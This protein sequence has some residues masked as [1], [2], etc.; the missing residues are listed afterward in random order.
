MLR[1]RVHL[2]GADLN[3][4]GDTLV[5]DH[6]GMERLIP[7]GP[8]HRKKVLETARDRRPCLVDDAD[9][10]VAVPD[11]RRDHAKR[12]QVIDLLQRGP[13][14][15]DFLMDAIGPLDTKFNPYVGDLC[16][17]E[18][19]LKSTLEL[20][21]RAAGRAAPPLDPGAGR[22][23]RLGVEVLERQILEL[24][25]DLPHS[26]SVGDGRVDVQGLLPDGQSSPLRH[27]AE[28]THVVQPV[29]QL[30][31]NDANVV[32]HGEQH[33]AEV[34][35]LSFLA[36]G[37]GDGADLGDTF[38]DMSHFGPKQFS[39][40]LDRGECVLNDVME[41]TSRNRDVIQTHVRHQ[42]SHLE[43]VGHIRLTGTSNLTGMLGRREVI[44][45]PQQ[46]GIGLWVEGSGLVG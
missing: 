46:L 16:L 12:D 25:F 10:R 29:G 27:V 3:L 18:R 36:R 45:S 2:L 38:H 32:D 7:I 13:L 4:K 23:I 41:Q 8:R 9:R 5:A 35:R 20:L 21:D 14:A 22:V 17:G 19:T 44:R 34:F 26:Q 6:R 15:S 30:D 24:V 42:G 37:E 40:P 39:H 43:G 11:R 28:R 33:L 1:D 31:E